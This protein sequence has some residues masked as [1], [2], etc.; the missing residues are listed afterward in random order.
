M[1]R[2]AGFFSFEYSTRSTS[3]ATV[4]PMASA[5]RCGSGGVVARLAHH[6]LPG[7]PYHD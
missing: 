5:A 1:L 3:T 7:D 6:H 4:V 2:P